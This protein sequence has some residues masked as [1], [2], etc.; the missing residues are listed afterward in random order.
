MTIF[1]LGWDS[2]EGLMLIIVG[3][4]AFF[5]PAYVLKFVL[6]EEEFFIYPFWCD[7]L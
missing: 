3:Q 4:K 1:S 7:Q 5:L 6:T 2:R